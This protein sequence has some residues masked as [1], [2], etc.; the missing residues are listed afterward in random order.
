M[1]FFD[2]ILG[3]VIGCGIELMGVVGTPYIASILFKYGVAPHLEGF[4][5]LYPLLVYGY[6]VFV[7]RTYLVAPLKI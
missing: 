7:R 6:F 4:L 2:L 1:N 3:V 5:F